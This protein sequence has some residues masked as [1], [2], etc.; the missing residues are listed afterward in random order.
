MVYN[1]VSALDKA[2]LTQYEKI[3]KTWESK[4]RSIY[5]LT[6]GLS[7]A[8]VS[9]YVTG[10]T[11]AYFLGSPQIIGGMR[12]EGYLGSVFL[13]SFFAAS[14]LAVDRRGQLVDYLEATSHIKLGYLESVKKIL[15]WEIAS[16]F[17]WKCFFW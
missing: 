16:L 1:P 5:S 8:S 17:S 11:T 14:S 6:F 10:D 3:R 4:G 12:T 15:S 7:V 9:L 13:Y 2:I